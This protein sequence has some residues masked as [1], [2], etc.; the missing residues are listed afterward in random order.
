M[1]F[2]PILLGG[3]LLATAVPALAQD[4]QPADRAT[5]EQVVRYLLRREPELVME[6]LQALQAKREADEAQQA[7][8]A[9]SANADALKGTAA[10]VVINPDGD[11]TMVEFMDYHCGYCKHMLPVLTKLIADDKKVRVVFKEFPILSEDSVYASRAGL[12]A[13]CFPAIHGAPAGVLV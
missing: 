11:V 8:Q 1:L 6:A 2:R 7:K 12:A 13:P 5:V 3:L 10:E 4:P 9:V